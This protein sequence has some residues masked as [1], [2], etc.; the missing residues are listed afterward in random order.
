MKTLVGWLANWLVGWLAG[1]LVW[2]I[3]ID[4]FKG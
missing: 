1:W 3:G 4:Y 2:L